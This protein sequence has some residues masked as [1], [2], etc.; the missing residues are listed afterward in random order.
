MVVVVVK[1]VMVCFFINMA[2]WAC[3]WVGLV[4]KGAGEIHMIQARK[5]QPK[6]E[7]V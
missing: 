3:G 7:E 2:V 1:R 6:V 4:G 5:A